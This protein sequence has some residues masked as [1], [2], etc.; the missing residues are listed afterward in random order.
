MK[1]DVII[2]GAGAAG[3]MAMRELVIAGYQ[4]CLL[5]AAPEAGGRIYTV[6]ENGFKEPVEA[7][8]EFIH[9]DLDLT[10]ELLK[11]A[12]IPYVPVDGQMIPVQHGKWLKENK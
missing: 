9:G 4:V 10:T 8:A 3:L 7:G 5:E 11:H 1:Y 6:N 12:G 2:I